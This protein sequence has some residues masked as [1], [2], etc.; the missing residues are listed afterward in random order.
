ME[1]E[2]LQSKLTEL[3]Q[4]LIRC[5]TTQ[6]VQGDSGVLYKVSFN[7]GPLIRNDFKNRYYTIKC[8]ATMNVEN[9]IFVPKFQIFPI[10]QNFLTEVGTPLST[11]TDT[12]YWTQMPT[13]SQQYATG[14][15]QFAPQSLEIYSNVPFFIETSYTDG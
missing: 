6:P 15:G 7:P 1:T 12:I 11:E 2:L 9:A 14:L 4:E 13:T 3:K 5:K 10:I 8:I